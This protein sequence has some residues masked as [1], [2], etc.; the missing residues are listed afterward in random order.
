MNNQKNSSDDGTNI[1]CYRYYIDC[2]GT[3]RSLLIMEY[4]NLLNRRKVSFI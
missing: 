1:L 3:T 2:F 4:M